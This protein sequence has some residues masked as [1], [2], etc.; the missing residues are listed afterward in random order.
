[1][2]ETTRTNAPD[3]PPPRTGV[4]R[5]LSAALDPS[6]DTSPG[7]DEILSDSSDVPVSSPYGGPARIWVPDPRPAS[8]DSSWYFWSCPTIDRETFDALRAGAAERASN[9]LQASS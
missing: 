6:F 7:P 9:R 1:M 8:K 4:A 5:V 3:E 2:L